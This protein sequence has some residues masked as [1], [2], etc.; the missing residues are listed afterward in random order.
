MNKLQPIK[1]SGVF[2]LM[3][4]FLLFGIAYHVVSA[5]CTLKGDIDCSGKVTQT[6]L[7]TLALSIGGSSTASDINKN[8]AVEIDD[9]LTLLSNFGK[10]EQTPVPTSTS[11]P[12]PALTAQPTATVTPSVSGSD[13]SF[14]CLENA[15]PLQVITGFYNSG[16]FEPATANNKKFDARKASFEIPS[17]ISHQMVSLRGSNMDSMCWA[18]GYITSS[19]SWHDLN[20]SWNESK[21]GYDNEG[22]NRGTM[23]NT[24]SA[25]SYGN[26]M[27]WT[28]LHVFNVHDGLRTSNSKDNWKIQ[29][30][31]FDYIRDDCIEN[32]H[33]YSGE[34]YDTLFDGCY[35]GLSVRPSAGS[36]DYAKGSV[37]KFDKVLLRMEP[38]PYPYKWDSKSDPTLKVSGYGETPFG[39]GNVFKMENGIEPDFEITNSVFL[40]EYDAKKELF[41]PQDKVRVCKNNTLIWLGNPA[42]A[43]TYLTSEFPGCFTIITDKTQGKAL[44]K[45]KVADWHKRHPDVGAHRK[46]SVPGEYKWPRY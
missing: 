20:I 1:Q 24:T 7:A 43:P 28:G 5:T 13:P 15:G 12:T 37:I 21:H 27:T 42:D 10:T 41:P 16:K 22:S 14:V 39:F 32:D 19:T 35:S 2:F 23:E 30:S 38:M 26:K 18:G 9:L 17:S 25:T 46:P 4:G 45:N 33:I 6:D 29:H 40:L 11:V 36:N 3:T 34:V 44:W 31:W 8:G